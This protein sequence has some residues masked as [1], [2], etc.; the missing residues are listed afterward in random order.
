MTSLLEAAMNGDLDAALVESVENDVDI[1]NMD[2]V[3]LPHPSNFLP[4]LF[5]SLVLSCLVW[6]GTSS[7]RHLERRENSFILIVS[8]L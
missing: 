4:P 7:P 6:R 5:P 8:H 1:N 3:L 2:E